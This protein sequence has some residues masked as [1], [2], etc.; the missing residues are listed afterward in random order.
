MTNAINFIQSLVAPE[1]L[2]RIVDWNK[3]RNNLDLDSNLEISMLAEEAK[4]YF[5]AETFVDQTDA[6]CD[7]LFVGV[8]TLAKSAKAFHLT[9]EG[10]FSPIEF[11]ISDYIAR[12][13][14]QGISTEV[15]GQFLGECLTAV[16]DANE[17]KGTEK[18]ENGKVIKPDD[19]V[20]PEQRIAA[21]LDS[22]LNANDA[23]Q[24]QQVFD[25]EK[26]GE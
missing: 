5:E 22:Y 26:G 3:A 4:E 18:D 21:I 25:F 10:L 7:L 23:G 15:I 13:A 20:A 14:E 1:Q 16:I 2:A 24:V 11:I 17:A 8:G 19:F 6:V 12:A 9:A